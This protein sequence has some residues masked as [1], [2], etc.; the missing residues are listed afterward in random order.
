MPV[1]LRV[2]DADG[3]VVA[4]QPDEVAY[5]TASGA[6]YP[7]LGPVLPWLSNADNFDDNEKDAEEWG[8]GTGTG[9]LEETEFSLVYRAGAGN[10]SATWPLKNCRAPV[11]ENWELQSDVHWEPLTFPESGDEAGIGLRVWHGTHVGTVRMQRIKTGAATARNFVAAE[12]GPASPTVTTVAAPAATGAVR[13]SYHA[14]KEELS[15]WYDPNGPAG[16]YSWTLLQKSRVGATGWNLPP[17]ALLEIEIGGWSAGTGVPPATTWLDN[18]RAA[19]WKPFSPQLDGIMVEQDAVTVSGYAE[20]YQ[21]VLAEVSDNLQTWADFAPLT[22]SAAGT[23]SF[24]APME[25]RKQ[26]YFRLRY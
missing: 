6:A 12:E 7:I 13:L 17:G 15:Y 11:T 18:F 16:G 22:A 20:P 2:L 26:R 1:L 14:G 24:T 5:E 25:N 19:S 23:L 21:S 9:V 8:D 10:H 3:N 4:V